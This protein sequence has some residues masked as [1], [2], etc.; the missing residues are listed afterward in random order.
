MSS[1]LQTTEFYDRKFREAQEHLGKHILVAVS[2]PGGVVFGKTVNDRSCQKDQWFFRAGDRCNIIVAGIGDMSDFDRVRGA[3]H[4]HD[5]M[6]EHSVGIAELTAAS[7][8]KYLALLYG[9]YLEE[10]QLLSAETIIAD[11]RENQFYAISISNR[12]RTYADFVVMGKDFYVEPIR[13]SDLTAT[14][15]M[16]LYHEIESRKSPDEIPPGVATKIKKRMEEGRFV[17]RPAI[18]F[19]KEQLADLS[20][21]K[22]D[23]EIAEHLVKAALFRFDPP[24]ESNLFQIVFFQ[25]QGKT[26]SVLNDE[27]IIS[28]ETLAEMFAAKPTTSDIQTPTESSKEKE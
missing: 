13:E 10:I 12:K 11:I 16:K 25:R 22:R 6:I 26:G 14:E 2:F 20:Y 21:Q 3:A 23:K 7:V 24:S 4:S 18:A 9:A 5:R 8:A 19:L 27:Q 15:M 1:I 17:R 28:R